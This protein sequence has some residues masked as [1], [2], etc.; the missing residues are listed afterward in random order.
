MSQRICVITYQPRTVV[1][2]LASGNPLTEQGARR[3]DEWKEAYSWMR[4]H[5]TARCGPPG[6]SNG[7]MLWGWPHGGEPEDPHDLSS[8]GD[9]ALFRMELSLAP[10]DTLVSDFHAW[11]IVLSGGYLGTDEADTDRYYAEAHEKTPD[12]VNEKKAS[13]ARIFNPDGLDHGYWGK[14]AE[15][16]YQLCFWPPKA[17]AIVSIR[18]VTV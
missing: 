11:H 8:G 16:I 14:P 7:L 5:L 10:E 17:E 3:E 18:K 15:R 13:W 6:A 1:D 4:A 2:V 12:S 9:D